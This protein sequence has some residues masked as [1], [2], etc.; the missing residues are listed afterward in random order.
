MIILD[1]PAPPF[2]VSS[3]ICCL[4]SKVEKKSN[5][6]PM[7]AE[8]MNAEP[9]NAEPVNELQFICHLDI[10]ICYFRFFRFIRVRYY[11]S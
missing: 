11:R 5:P 10:E 9:M 2:V 8:P 3:N 1:E 4:M 7:N 6:E